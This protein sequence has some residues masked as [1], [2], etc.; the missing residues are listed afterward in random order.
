MEMTRGRLTNIRVMQQSTENATQKSPRP[1]RVD[2]MPEYFCS[3]GSWAYSIEGFNGHLRE[4]QTHY[5]VNK[6]KWKKLVEGKDKQP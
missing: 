2:S 6:T 3:S 5:R 1:S 4:N